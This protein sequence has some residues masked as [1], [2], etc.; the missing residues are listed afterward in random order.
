MDWFISIDQA[1]ELSRAVSLLELYVRF[2]IDTSGEVPV[3][4]GAA[5]DNRYS[6]ITFASDFNFEKVVLTLIH[7]VR[8]RSTCH[9][10]RRS[11]LNQLGGTLESIVGR[12]PDFHWT[13]IC[14]IRAGVGQTLEANA[15]SPVMFWTAHSRGFPIGPFGPALS[16]PMDTRLVRSIIMNGWLLLSMADGY[17]QWLVIHVCFT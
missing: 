13:A 5:G 15:C 2:R 9:F 3:F 10:C 16:W 7:V 4:C 6:V 12:A 17:C 8:M 1:S 14:A 11:H